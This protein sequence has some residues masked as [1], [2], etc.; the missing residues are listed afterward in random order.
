MDKMPRETKSRINENRLTMATGS[1]I[2]IE[3]S[4]PDAVL[5]FW[6][7]PLRDANDASR[8]NWQYGMLRWRI[9]PFA[10]SHED[11]DIHL[12]QRRWCEQ[13]HRE[14]R[15]KFFNNPV[16]DSPGGFLAK[17][18]ILDQ[19]PR[20]VYRGTA[21]AY[22]NDRLTASMA[23]QACQGD[24]EFD[25]YN[26]I[27]RLWIYLPL[28]HVEDMKVQQFLIEK[29]SRWSADL[30][31]GVPP[32]K[33]RIN[34]F[35]SW[36]LLRA[37]IEHSE[38]LLLF[39]RFP[40]RNGILQR[41][42]RGGEHRYLT[43]PLRPLWSFTQPPNPIYFALL[44][45]LFRIGEG[46]EENLVSREA[47]SGMLQMAGLSPEDPSSPMAVFELID[48]N[49]VPF[50]FLYQHLSLP[51]HAKALDL[52]KQ[53]P[54]VAGLTNDIKAL[55]L[56][57]G[58][59]EWPPRSAK[60]SVNPA[61]DVVALNTL[62]CG[63]RISERS[64]NMIPDG[65]GL[66]VLDTGKESVHELNLLVRNDPGETVR[67]SDRIDEFADQN[68]FPQH[69]RFQV[70]LIIEET[71]I[72]I[73]ERNLEDNRRIML[74][75]DMDEDGRHL[76]INTVDHG[77]ELEFNALIFQ[78]SPDTIEEENVV[79]NVGL[80]LVRTYVDKIQYRR[81]NEVNY[82]NMQKRISI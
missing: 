68:G 2:G 70:Q 64:E 28:C 4:N 57:E 61:I 6:L 36:Y 3:E 49:R 35:V 17:L 32:D 19:F 22:E 65:S 58:E 82:L 79:E 21:V 77:S 18:I 78:P 29:L 63:D 53:V 73:I 1:N 71:L 52:L 75:M 14:G 62:I 76:S 66:K 20:T 41:P 15:E 47:L 51:E 26:I 34:Q 39:D 38:T 31:S 16:W 59:R 42:H 48:R 46:L 80:H 72:Y 74:H 67:V 11:P 44:A 60:H 43:D 13:L 23:W 25:Q 5:D 55:I 69:E 33:K 10:R 45:A 27:E 50:P 81:E 54:M 40:Q 56:K 37:V 24:R 30:V 9:G 8:K 7:G 12:V